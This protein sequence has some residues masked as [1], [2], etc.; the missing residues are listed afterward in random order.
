MNDNKMKKI[1]RELNIW[2]IIL[3][4]TYMILMHMVCSMD[5]PNYVI[6]LLSVTI[7]VSF[8]AIYVMK[9]N[10]VSEKLKNSLFEDFEG[11]EEEINDVFDDETRKKVDEIVDNLN[12]IKDEEEVEI[13]IKKGKGGEADLEIRNGTS[14]GAIIC[15][16][17]AIKAVADR[18]GMNGE[19]LD[20]FLH[21]VST[22]ET[23]GDDKNGD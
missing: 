1:K 11:F 18:H 13:K 9:L 12:E 6:V 14:I 8:L 17:S 7:V 10:V 20:F 2:K 23:E 22:T 16:V 21:N 3:I 5:A 4:I 15:L 19:V